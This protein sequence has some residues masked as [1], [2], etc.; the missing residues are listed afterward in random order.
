MCSGSSGCTAPTPTSRSPASEALRLD[1][2]DESAREGVLLA[3]KARHPVYAR[4]LQFFLWESRLPSQARW[5]LL[6]A[7][8]VVGHAIRTVHNDAVFFP[9]AVVFIGLIVLTW[10]AEPVMTLALLATR[11]GRRVVGPASRVAA[12]LFGG[13]IAAAVL[14]GIAA[15]LTDTHF[16]I[17]SLGFV[18]FA[19]AAGNVDSLSEHRRKTF[20]AGTALY[21]LIA[22]VYAAI[23]AAGGGYNAQIVPAAVLIFG[24]VPAIWYVRLAS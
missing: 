16:L 11:E 24:G 19:L 15:A 7:P 3:L 5:A 12:A 10:A 13:F 18:F 17:I 2:T 9:L 1:P 14:F 21:L 20:F 23:I 6:F 8:F 4:L 22:V